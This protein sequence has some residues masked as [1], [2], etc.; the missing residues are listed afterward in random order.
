MALRWDAGLEMGRGTK[1]KS[2]DA[3]IDSIL[4][5]LVCHVEFKIY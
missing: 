3:S 4:E 2:K 1:D 5:N